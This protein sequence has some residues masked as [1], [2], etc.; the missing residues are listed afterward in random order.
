[1]SASDD[2]LIAGAGPAGSLAALLLARAG[3]RVRLLDRDSFP[4]DK[5][6]GDSLNPGAM[7]RLER[8]G[9][10]GPVRE[11]G[12]PIAGMLLTGPRGAAVR[13]TYGAGRL[14]RSLPRRLLDTTLVDAAVAAGARLETGVVVK[15]PV[16]WGERGRRRVTGVQVRGPDGRHGRRFASMV[17]AA[18]GRRSPCALAL[19]LS[20]HPSTP[21]RWAVGAYFENVSGLT[22]FGEMHVRRG[23]Y[24]GVAPVPGG[25]ANVCLVCEPSIPD[26]DLRHPARSLERLL[27]ADAVLGHRFR[28]AHCVS[29]VRVLGPL[30]VD[31]DAA[32]VPGLLL[33]GDAAGFVD[34]MTGDGLRLAIDGAELA[35][36]AVLR[37]LSGTLAAPHEWLTVRRREAF[38]VKLRVNR[39]LRSL[40]GSPA[41]LGTAVALSRVTPWP[42]HRV[43]GYAGDA[44]V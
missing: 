5:L 4:R 34:P 25:L 42:F 44:G 31:V 23:H 7:A 1:M 14:G 15:G 13:G 24:I 19:G 6:C 16:G 33:A 17:I 28:H 9:V 41:A 12:L 20:R 37:S 22:S 27:G 26:C 40:V 38:G 29:D 32:G 43:I 3:A 18:D 11:A 30:A 36:D 10:A 2:V 21:R 35:A 39:W 8:L